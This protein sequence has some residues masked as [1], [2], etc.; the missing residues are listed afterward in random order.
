MPISDAVILAGGKSSRM[1]RDKALLPFGKYSSLA[2]YQYRR[3]K[4]IFPKVSLSCKENKFSFAAEIL[5][6]T[7]P[8]SSPMVALTSI[9]DTLG[10]SVFI[11]G[12]DMPFVEEESIKK[13]L[14]CY[15]ET[16]RTGTAVD[17]LLAESPK[18]IE[19][20][21]GIYTPTAGI[22][23][24]KLLQK[25]NHKMHELPNLCRTETVYFEK[26]EL[27]TNLNRPEEYS[28]ARQKI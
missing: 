12:V 3:L 13:M 5:S 22:A 1:G 11:L 16:I 26:A 27:F 21:C 20:L 17:I 23:A 7:S 15:N 10:R 28:L 18:G 6:D 24:R 2:E 14:E 4:N 9:L 25:N 8:V 19:P